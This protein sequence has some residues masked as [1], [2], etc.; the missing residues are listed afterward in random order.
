[1]R[2][3]GLKLLRIATIDT[4]LSFYLAFIYVDRPYYDK[5]RILCMCELLFDMQQKNR[6]KLR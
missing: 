1:M 6:L 2:A 5:N 3:Q 4:M